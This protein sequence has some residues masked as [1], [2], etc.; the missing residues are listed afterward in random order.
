MQKGHFGWAWFSGHS[1]LEVLMEERGQYR[2]GDPAVWELRL[3]ATL[4]LPFG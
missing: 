1:E 4:F 2:S 3:V